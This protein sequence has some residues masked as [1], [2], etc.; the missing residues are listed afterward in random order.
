MR[1]QK[2]RVIESK[3]GGET[4]ETPRD[5]CYT[6][7]RRDGM[8][9][10]MLCNDNIYLAIEHYETDT[11]KLH[12]QIVY[13]PVSEN[14]TTMVGSYSAYRFDPFETSLASETI[15][16]G[17]PYIAQTDN[18]FA[19]AYQTFDEIN[20][21]KVH[22]VMNVQVCPKSEMDEDKFE[23]KMRA[24]T[25][26][27]EGDGVKTGINWPS[28]CPLGGDEFLAVYELH[29]ITAEGREANQHV[30]AIRGRITTST[31]EFE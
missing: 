2:I 12:P 3:D 15:Y 19:I 10:A 21:T 13:N 27:P 18:Y 22:R 7:R 1:Y 5:V 6:A 30:K 9:T 8:P 4:W 26:I 29:D 20:S 16:N 23:G 11:Q 28:I 24:K 25:Q 17:A 14:W 31:P